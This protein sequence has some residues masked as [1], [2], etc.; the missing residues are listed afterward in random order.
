MTWQL[1]LPALSSERGWT[2]LHDRPTEDY[3]LP[4]SMEGKLGFTQVQ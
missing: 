2:A 3:Y 4:P 1:I